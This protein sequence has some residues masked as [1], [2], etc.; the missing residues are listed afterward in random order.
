MFAARR[1]LLAHGIRGVHPDPQWRND[2][3]HVQL[4]RGSWPKNIKELVAGSKKITPEMVPMELATLRSTTGE[5]V[6]LIADLKTL[7]SSALAPPPS[8]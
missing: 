5:I 7:R 2:I 3:W 1:D 4:A 6:Q 8:P